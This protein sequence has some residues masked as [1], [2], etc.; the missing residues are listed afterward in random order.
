LTRTEARLAA[1]PDPQA[2][3]T[4]RLLGWLSHGALSVSPD[5]VGNA[6]LL[7]M[8]VGPQLAGIVFVLAT[9]PWRRQYAHR[10]TRRRA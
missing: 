10:Q 5:D 1:V 3:A 2:D 7:A 6:R 8:V 4:A 9:A